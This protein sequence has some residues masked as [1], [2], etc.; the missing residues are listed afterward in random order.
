[1]LHRQQHIRNTPAEGANKLALVDVNAVFV[2]KR[3]SVHDLG[4]GFG[5]WGSNMTSRSNV[6]II[7][8][9]LDIQRQLKHDLKVQYQHHH[10][11][12]CALL[13][14][15]LAIYLSRQVP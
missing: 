12:T 14:V 15:K 8:D 6:N 1:V 9:Q 7:I 4:V 3:G 11:P 5:V 10:E 2:F 13:A